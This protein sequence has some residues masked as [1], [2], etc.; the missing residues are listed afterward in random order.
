[1]DTV[2]TKDM[3]TISKLP[4]G[5]YQARVRR[6]GYPT[7][8]KIFLN[9]HT[10]LAWARKTESEVE[11]SVY[12]DLSD[13][14]ELKLSFV[15]TRYSEE[16]AVTH[17]GWRQEQSRCKGV[18]G[19]LGARTPLELTPSALAEYSEDRPRQVSPKTA[20]EELSPLQRVFNV[21]LKD[22]GITLRWCN[23]DHC[24]Y[25]RSGSDQE[26]SDSSG[27]EAPGVSTNA[28][29][30]EQCIATV[31][32]VCMKLGRVDFAAPCRAWAG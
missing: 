12:L 9:R 7:L 11:R 15:L 16:I 24:L 18:S 19:R 25:R 6:G 22:W 10:A 20:R 32:P 23:E 5:M 1:M 4:S 17:K 30:A 2:S 13:S 21:C 27:G 3:A 14:K 8:S 26:D 31:G 28:A 29:A